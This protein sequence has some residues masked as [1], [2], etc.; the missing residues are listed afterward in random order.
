VPLVKERLFARPARPAS[1]AAGGQQQVENAALRLSNFR[2]YF[3][4]VLHLARDQYTLAP[5]RAGSVLVAGTILGRVA[6]PTATQASHLR[7]M[8]QPAGRGAPYIDPKPVLD[9]WKLLQATAIYRASGKDPFL[10]PGAGGATSGQVLLMSKQQLENRVLHDPHVTVYDCGRRDIAAGEIDRRILATI[11]F[12]SVSGLDPT[13]SR[14]NCGNPGATGTTMD[15]SQIDRI[16]IQGHQGTGSIT[17]IT[18]RRLLTLQGAMA[19]S[20]IISLMSYKGQ[21]NTIS[22]PDHARQIEVGFTPQFGENAKLSGQVR[23]ILQPDQ[24]VKLI[25]RIG[26]IPEPTVPTAPSRYAIRTR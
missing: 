26:Q 5:L 8:V 20:Q 25:Q 2:N 18:I 17:D 14:L 23:Q 3:S 6:R 15:I 19:P 13:I 7:F 9:G 24:W 11:E 10:G 16:P 21:T 22:L 1:F 12:L 4:D